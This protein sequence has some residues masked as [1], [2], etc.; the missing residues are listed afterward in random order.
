MMFNYLGWNDAADL[1]RHGLEKAI[2]DRQVTYDLER[3]MEGAALLKCSEFGQ[4]IIER[5]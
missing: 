3:Q 5:M 4:A 1:I 2:M